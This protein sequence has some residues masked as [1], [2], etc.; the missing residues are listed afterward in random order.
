M[1]TGF[2]TWA[3]EWTL[4]SYL[5]YE[6]TQ[7]DQ[8]IFINNALPIIKDKVQTQNTDKPQNKIVL[9]CWYELKDNSWW[10]EPSVG[11]Y[12]EDN[13]G[14]LRPDFSFK[15][16]YNSLQIQIG[17]FNQFSGSEGYEISQ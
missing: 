8:E 3:P 10:Q 9:A 17:E 4:W 15:I 16:G 14:I 12:T 6:H 7:D 5:G 11:F 2:S 1:E 13:F